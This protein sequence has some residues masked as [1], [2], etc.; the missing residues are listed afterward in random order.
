[1]MTKDK[2]IKVLQE[3]LDSR[4]DDWTD[5]LMDDDM[6]DDLVKSIE[7]ALKC[8]VDENTVSV[9]SSSTFG[10]IIAN[11]VNSKVRI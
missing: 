8:M 9:R 5:Y 1:M 10:D 2:A 6:S 7:I 3:F 4:D 11:Y